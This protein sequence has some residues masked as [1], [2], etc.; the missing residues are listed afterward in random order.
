MRCVLYIMP[1]L[2]VAACA[3]PRES[4]IYTAQDQLRV[5]DGRIATAQGNV[6]RGF[7][8]FTATDTRT[9]EATC[10]DR[11]P[12]GQLE[13]YD[14][15]RTE[16]FTTSSP[17]AIDVGEERRKLKRLRDQRPALQAATDTAVR[18]CIAIH[19]E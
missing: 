5:L 15:D 9:I 7:A 13:E 2:A 10:T 12:D 17:V 16:T 3:T 1:L 4:C 11:L 19:P 6:D 8:V 18:Q 14:C